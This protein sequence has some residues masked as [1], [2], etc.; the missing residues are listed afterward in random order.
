[1]GGGF[2]VCAVV[3]VW[4][5]VMAFDGVGG[6]KNQSEAKKEKKDQGLLSLQ[7]LVW[8]VVVTKPGQERRARLEL[9]RQ[10]FPV[11]LPMKLAM[12]RRPG[13]AGQ[14]LAS[15]FFPRYL[16]AQVSLA[17][18]D[19]KKIWY[20]IGVQGLLGTNER[21]IGVKD[22]LVERIRAAE[23]DGFIKI[24]LEADGPRFERHQRVVVE[25]GGVDIEGVFMERV[26][27][28]RASLLVSCLGRDSRF[29]VDLRKLRSAGG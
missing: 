17:V 11:Y 5:A 24:G 16:F 9:E 12:D 26:D 22:T 23:E 2:G 10:G 14:L 6:M 15:P 13:R 28:K 1:M 4:G 18:G 19:W 7:Q 27:E 8:V 3:D 21:P 25:V 20:T 29:T